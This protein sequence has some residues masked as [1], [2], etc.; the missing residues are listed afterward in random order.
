MPEIKALFD[1]ATATLTYVVSDPKSR[2]AVVID[3]VLDYDAASGRT[4]RR[5][6]DEISAYVAA[7]NLS[8]RM[9]LET[10]PHA[11]HL[12]GAAELKARFPHAPVAIG[13]GIEQVQL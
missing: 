13:A 7:Q 9:I 10:H 12:S 6:L 4:S 3:A 11:D 2:D 8:V 1:S 5:S